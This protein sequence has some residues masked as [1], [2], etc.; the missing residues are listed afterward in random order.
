MT[1]TVRTAEYGPVRSVVWE[2]IGEAYSSPPLS[3]LRASGLRVGEVVV[4]QPP[5]RR[6]RPYTDIP[7][8]RGRRPPRPRQFVS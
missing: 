5:V 7:R 1:S 4:L 8:P 6:D 2:G 3:R